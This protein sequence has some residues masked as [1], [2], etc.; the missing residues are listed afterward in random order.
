[1]ALVSKGSIRI[2]GEALRDILLKRYPLPQL[3]VDPVDKPSV[4]PPQ[5]L[6]QAGPFASPRSA[7]EAVAL[8]PIIASD[9][10]ID[11]SAS[12]LPYLL[13]IFDSFASIGMSVCHWG[14]NNFTLLNAQAGAGAGALARTGRLHLAVVDSA[15]RLIDA[16]PIRIWV[17]KGGTL[18]TH[19][20]RS[21]IRNR[22]TGDV[23]AHGLVRTEFS[24]D[25]PID[26]VITWVNGGDPEWRDLVTKHADGREI[27]F[28]RYADNDELRFAIRSIC[29]FAPWIRTIFVLSNC[30]PP[31]WFESTPRVKWIDHSE[32][33]DGKYLP[34]FN[35]H[36][37]ELMLADIPGLSEHFIYVNDDV[38]IAKPVRPLDFFN[39]DGT[40]VSFME[41]SG[42]VLE[43]R[44]DGDRA[45]WEYAAANG[46]ELIQRRFGVF[47]TRLHQHVPFA[48]RRSIL[49]GLATEF[50]AEI[51][52]TKAARFRSA[53]D[54]SAISFLYHHYARSIGAGVFGHSNSIIVRSTNYADFEEKV[55]R[56]AEFQF[57]CVNDGNGSHADQKYTKFKKQ[58]LPQMFPFKSECESETKDV[59]GLKYSDI[60]KRGRDSTPLRRVEKLTLVRR[61]LHKLI[62]PIV[63]PF[64]SPDDRRRFCQDP[65]EY[66]RKAKAPSNRRIGR[67]LLTKEQRPY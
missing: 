25:Q 34:L 67:I 57:I 59:C 8:S 14:K 44:D 63:G 27:D 5:A 51:E 42:R 55:R 20:A 38:M 4:D 41:A 60:F 26:A 66:L 22:G 53:S 43:F 23:R 33:N 35:S 52:R 47:P 36:S 54:V 58:F 7:V 9:D 31:A 64:Q 6:K 19:D 10:C 37:I 12:Y 17:A 18:H 50:P 45:E 15:A 39:A 40:S 29:T 28:D 56:G 2:P 21:P 16:F 30:R 11:V 13:N 48:L 32:V 3:Q 65:I 24:F 62:V 49:N 46:A 1:M 61:Q